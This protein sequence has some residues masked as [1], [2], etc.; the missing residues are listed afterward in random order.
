[1]DWYDLQQSGDARAAVLAFV[2]DY[3]PASFV[4]V[5]ENAIPDIIET[6]GEYVLRMFDNWNVILWPDLSRP[7]ASLLSAMLESGEL[8]LEPCEP[9][10]YTLACRGVDL[11][12][13]SDIDGTEEPSWLPCLLRTGGRPKHE[14]RSDEIRNGR[15]LRDRYIRSHS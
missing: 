5:I 14:C 13:V 10:V 11:P 2:R 12:V 1:M 9:L 3:E 7:V 15:Q 6:R 4:E 8:A